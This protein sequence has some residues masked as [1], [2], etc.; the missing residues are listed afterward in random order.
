VSIANGDVEPS[1]TDSTIF[2]NTILD[3]SSWVGYTIENTGSAVL[4]LTGGSPY[5]FVTGTHASDFTL[6][7]VP[8]A[9]ISA[10]GGTTAFTIKFTPTGEAEGIRT[11]TINIASDDDDDNPYTF[12]ISGTALP[13]PKPL[14]EIILHVNGV[15]G[16]VSAPGD[17]LTYTAYYWNS[18]VGVANTVVIDE[19]IPVQT[20]YV[21]NSAE[22][23]GMTITFQHAIV[24]VYNSSQEAPV[25]GIKY[26]L[27][28]D[29]AS[30][31]LGNDQKTLSFRVV[32]D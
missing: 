31:P 22:G 29:L 3:S 8:Q 7:L 14:L 11:A 5:V 26:E 27:T 24:D 20:T 18:G 15:T 30:D 9:T 12:S 2:A 23:T 16:T 28:T 1:V 25:T 17:T 4:S 6:T 21:E 10:G 32:V 13:M 19:A